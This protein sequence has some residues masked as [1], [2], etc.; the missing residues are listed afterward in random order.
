MSFMSFMQAKDYTYKITNDDKVDGFYVSY[1]P[2]TLQ[3][4]SFMLIKMKFIHCHTCVMFLIKSMS[5]WND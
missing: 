3:C 2:I 1:K 5:I 4:I